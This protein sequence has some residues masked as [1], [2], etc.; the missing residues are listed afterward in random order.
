MAVT[1]IAANAPVGERVFDFPKKQQVQL[2]DLKALFR[3]SMPT[4]SSGQ[5]EGKLRGT[6]Y[7]EETEYDKTGK[8][9]KRDIKEYSFFY[10][11][12]SEISTL[13]KKDGQPLSEEEQQKEN[14]KTQKEIKDIQKAH[15]KKEVKEEK[16]KE[17][18]KEG[19]DDDDVGIGLS[20]VSASS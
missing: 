9:T 13:T 5:A 14:E 18:G 11:D 17:E 7:E 6:R 1:R 20:C 3:K 16:A 15:E 19:K 4:R 2:P 10:L 12:G 8:I